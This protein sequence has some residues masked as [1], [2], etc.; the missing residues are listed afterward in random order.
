[1]TVLGDPHAVVDDDPFGLGV[2]VAG[3]LDIRS[4][5]AGGLFDLVPGGRVKIGQQFIYAG[6]VICDEVAVE[7]TC[8]AFGEALRVERHEGLHDSLQHRDVAADLHQIIGRGDRRRAQRQ[9]FDGVLRRSEPL[10]PALAQRVEDDDR[11]ASL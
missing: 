11:H 10:Q 8:A 2:D 6:R 7:N 4:R 5:Q 3:E 1:V 9:H